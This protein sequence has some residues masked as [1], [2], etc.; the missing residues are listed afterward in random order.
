MSSAS[1]ETKSLSSSSFIV[2]FR[3]VEEFDISDEND[4]YEKLVKY[5]KN[6]TWFYFAK[7]LSAI[8]PEY[9]KSTSISYSIRYKDGS[10]KTYFNNRTIANYDAR[11]GFLSYDRAPS[12][13]ATFY[14]VLITYQ[15]G[16]YWIDFASANNT[17]RFVQSTAVTQDITNAQGRI[18]K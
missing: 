1:E 17:K 12:S 9:Q 5:H 4:V 16:S 2:Q 11:G 18:V 7:K 15:D 10:M 14:P 6:D 8:A 3:E 13:F